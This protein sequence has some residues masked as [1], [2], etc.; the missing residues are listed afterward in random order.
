MGELLSTEGPKNYIYFNNRVWSG[1]T[2]YFFY[3]IGTM[4]VNVVAHLLVTYKLI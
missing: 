2:L 3:L 4:Q 1:P